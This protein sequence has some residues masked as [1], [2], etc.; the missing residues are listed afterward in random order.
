MVR[1]LYVVRNAPAR[2]GRRIVSPGSYGRPS[3]RKTAPIA[4]Y[5]TQRAAWGILPLGDNPGNVKKGWS[6]RTLAVP[7]LAAK[8]ARPPVVSRES[9]TTID[10]QSKDR[11]I[12]RA[13]G[14]RVDEVG[15]MGLVARPGE[16]DISPIPRAGSGHSVAIR[17]PQKGHRTRGFCSPAVPRLV[18]HPLFDFAFFDR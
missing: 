11:M 15:E 6:G 5:R 4:H 17:H 7:T 16:M 12:H 1:S 8:R 18:G 14:G 13:Y 3:F 2:S 10:R 9:N